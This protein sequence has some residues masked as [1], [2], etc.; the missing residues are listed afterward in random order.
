MPEQD[1][2][3][4]KGELAF[5]LA[6]GDGCTTAED[7]GKEEEEEVE[8][9]EAKEPEDAELF[10]SLRVRCA[11]EAADEG[12]ASGSYE[13]SSDQG[14]WKFSFVGWM[15]ADKRMGGRCT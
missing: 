15:A 11:I 6:E 10:R 9:E 8:E 13:Q 2:R 3:D 12:R 1:G 7:E 4:T 14:E 5:H